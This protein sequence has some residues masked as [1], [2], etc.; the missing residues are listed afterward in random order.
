M[1]TNSNIY[2]IIYSTV[3]VVVVAAVLSIVATTLK[4]KQQANVDQETQ[5]SLLN[6]INIAKD[7]NNYKGAE[8]A[9]YVTKSY[10]KYVTDS[11]VVDINGN[12]VEG[13][14]FKISMKHQYDILRN[15]VKGKSK[16]DVRLPIFVCS[17]NDSTKVQIFSVYGTGLWGPIW[18]YLALNSDFNT[19]YGAYFGNAG[20]TPGLGAEI[21]SPWF[22]KQFKGKEIFKDNTFCSISV[23][24]GGAKGDIHGV[25]AVSGGTI[26][27]RSLDTTIRQWLEL[28]LP[29]IQKEKK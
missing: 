3:L 8:R 26:T 9:E 21:S 15:A 29:Y 23:V 22:S 2:T 16:E 11:Y 19:V 14:A 6:A 12:K 20:E 28:Y 7:V 17:L 1:N 10:E 24:K 5:T 27:S 25:D 13:D 18:G 4:D